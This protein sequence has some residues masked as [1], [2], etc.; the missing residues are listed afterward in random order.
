MSLANLRERRDS[1][2][3]RP[4]TPSVE[5]NTGLE[6]QEERRCVTAIL[7]MAKTLGEQAVAAPSPAFE[8]A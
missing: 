2:E 7:I 5:A 4:D 3:T 8:I 6:E 1:P